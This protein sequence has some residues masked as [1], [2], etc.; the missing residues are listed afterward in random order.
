MSVSVRPHTRFA[1]ALVAA[2]VVSAASVVSLPEPRAIPTLNVDVVNASA[3]TDTL[4]GLGRGV[5][6]LSSL[7]GIHVDATISLPFEA[8]LALMA[9]AE[10]PEL[11]PNILSYLVQR[12]VNPAVGPPI[13]AYPWYTEQTFAVIASLLPYPLGP[14]AT[15][16]GFVNEARLAFADAFNSVLGQLPDPLPGF[17][18][19]NDV[20]RN[21]VLGRSVVAGQLAVRAPLYVVWNTVD[22]LGMLPANLEAAFESAIQTPNQIPG[23]ISYL[24]HG[25]L[26]PDP[27]VGLLGKLLNNVVDPFTWLPSPI[28]ASADGTGGLAN[29]IRSLIVGLMNGLLS[30]LPA[31]VRPSALPPA[32]DGPVTNGL[33]TAQNSFGPDSL[34]S[35]SVA[36]ENGI[37]LV[38]TD[39]VE[40][41]GE[42]TALT[43]RSVLTPSVEESTP[44]TPP[45]PSDEESTPEASLTPPVEDVTPATPPAA[46]VDVAPEAP[47]HGADDGAGHRSRRPRIGYRRHCTCRRG[48]RLGGV[49]GQGRQ[50]WP[51]PGGQTEGAQRSDGPV[52][53]DRRPQA[54]QDQAGQDH[55]RQDHATQDHAGSG[56]IRRCGR[57][58]R[59]DRTAGRRKHAFGG[60]GQHLGRRRLIEQEGPGLHLKAG[61]FSCRNLG[62]TPSGKRHAVVAAAG[63]P[64]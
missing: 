23:L 31:P 38:S 4:Y 62:R 20:M 64:W 2:G 24:V 1:A 18:A 21:T 36:I 9:A 63:R 26:S 47:A 60:V 53:R 52:D 56:R 55:A 42:T 43:M 27:K 16:I 44:E 50:G 39:D 54:G 29:G 61:P 28:G 5:G 8:T 49:G 7:V 58:G 12:F 19:V 11:S 25:L 40:K 10:H 35:A 57:T 33:P 14:S 37:A 41:A 13:T 51:G 6:V 46:H 17:D 48:A 15:E 59:V 32:T 30:F 45:A 22:Y 34:P 3:I